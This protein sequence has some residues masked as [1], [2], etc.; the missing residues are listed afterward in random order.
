MC[1]GS[2]G[3]RSSFSAMQKVYLAGWARVDLS[4]CPG[5]APPILRITKRRARPMVALARYPLPNTPASEFTF[6]C[7]AMGPLTTMR[8]AAPP[9]VDWM[10]PK[11]YSVWQTALTAASTTGKCSGLHP[12]ITALMATFSTVALPL[13]G[14]IR[15]NTS[16]GASRPASSMARTRSSVG[17]TMGSPSVQPRSSKRSLMASSESGALETSRVDVRY[18]ALLTAVGRQSRGYFM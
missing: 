17:G 9:V 6:N 12:A 10:P 5:I 15:P 8:G 1:S 4:V 13:I 3:L 18:H 16:E 14:G 2:H 11:L 7:F